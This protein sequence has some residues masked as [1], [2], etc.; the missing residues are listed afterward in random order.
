MQSYAIIQTITKHLEGVEKQLS[1][2]YLRP[3]LPV[4]L[5]RHRRIR[6]SQIFRHIFLHLILRLFLNF[7]P[8]FFQNLILSLDHLLKSILI[9]SLLTMLQNDA[10]K[11]CH[12]LKIKT[13][14]F[15]LLL[16]LLATFDEL[17]LFRLKFFLYLL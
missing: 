9:N 8:L 2:N 11:H 1:N 10:T 17:P 13:N 3:L 4:F 12:N 5:N 16:K 7:G 6:V 15:Q 14:L